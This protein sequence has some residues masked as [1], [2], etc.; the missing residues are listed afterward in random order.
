MI[1]TQGS[2]SAWQRLTCFLFGQLGEDVVYGLGVGVDAKFLHQAIANHDTP[3]GRS[4]PLVFGK[5]FSIHAYGAAGGPKCSDNVAI[6]KC[7]FVGNPIIRTHS[8]IP[9][10]AYAHIFAAMHGVAQRID[11]DVILRHQRCQLVLLIDGI[12]KRKN[13]FDGAHGTCTQ[14]R[15]IRSSL[16]H[17]SLRT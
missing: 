4:L 9:S 15:P 11:K 7:V 14:I 17:A 3:R 13:G 2:A 8:E 12:E 5:Q 6:V 10:P 1:L 16:R